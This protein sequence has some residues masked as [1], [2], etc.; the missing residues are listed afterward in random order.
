MDVIY[1]WL[2]EVPTAPPLGGRTEPHV[3]QG[4]NA[5]CMTAFQQLGITD[6][7]ILAA[8]VLGA[9]RLGPRMCSGLLL[10]LEGLSA[11]ESAHAVGLGD[12]MSLWRAAGRYGLRAVHNDRHRVRGAIKKV[13]TAQTM[14]RRPRG[15]LMGSMRGAALATD[16][17]IALDRVSPTAL[18][19]YEV[20]NN[21]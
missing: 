2:N 20:R 6:P 10:Y 7:A 18:A 11:R 8:R 19:G 3:D 17:A 4:Y 14:L 9:P 1:S 21:G 13:A 12:H 15:G 5:W 16:A